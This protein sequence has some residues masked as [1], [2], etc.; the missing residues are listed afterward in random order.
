MQFLNTPKFHEFIRFCIV[1]GLCTAIDVCGFYT[2][3]N[4]VGYQIALIIGFSLSIIVNYFLNIKWTF[5]SRLSIK[6]ALGLIGANCF[7]IF[8]VRMTL[9]WIFISV[10]ELT[11]DI[12]F[13]PTLLISIAT[14]FIIV[15]AIIMGIA[16][17]QE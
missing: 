10:F 4:A 6:N 12:A 1:G 17:H 2:T 3:Y 8:V 14:N 15:R 5:Q 7:N 16:R 13:I 9:M 11:E